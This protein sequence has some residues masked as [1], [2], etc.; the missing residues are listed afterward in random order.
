M[1][2]G[3]SYNILNLHCSEFDKGILCTF[4]TFTIRIIKILIET[5]INYFCI[6]LHCTHYVVKLFGFNVSIQ[7]S[8]YILPT[9]L[10]C[11]QSLNQFHCNPLWMLQS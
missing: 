8:V 2:D 6:K 4:R 11:R 7:F 5:A 9:K 3:S 1:L 10:V